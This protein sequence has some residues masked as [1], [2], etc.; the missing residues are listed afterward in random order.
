MAPSRVQ[1]V[2]PGFQT[3][4]ASTATL[5][6]VAVGDLMIAYI[7]WNALTSQLVSDIQGGLSST[8]S[9]AGGWN[10]I[11]G[12]Y[13]QVET[14]VGVV[15][16]WAIATTAGS[17]A[18]HLSLNAT[19]VSFVDLNAEQVTGWTSSPAL[20]T[21]AVSTTATGSP[22]SSGGL[23]TS[24]TDEWVVGWGLADNAAGTTWTATFGTI[25]D[26]ATA[27]GFTWAGT[28]GDRAAAGSIDAAFTY[29]GG[30]TV[31]SKAMASAAFKV[32]FGDTVIV[33]T[34]IQLS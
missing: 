32:S 34:Q 11:A 23:S 19:N 28:S 27:G 31:I 30:G 12:T 17:T 16:A 20:D 9:P 33:S 13:G 22:L 15:I 8:P 4:A 2:S 1:V 21:Q 26:N 3:G 29:A 25:F 14:F 18:V 5:T 7:W 6:S 10:V 24:T